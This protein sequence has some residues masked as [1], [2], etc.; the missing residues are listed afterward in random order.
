M[1]W[2]HLTTHD[3]AAGTNY[4]Y[5]ID[6]NLDVPD[7]ASRYQP[8]DVTGFSQVVDPEAFQWQCLDWRGRPWEETI[9]YELH[10]G[11]F[12]PEGTFTAAIAKLDGLVG[13]GRHRHRTDAT[14]RLSGNAELGL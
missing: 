7:P 12:T 13:A 4:R 3:A 11:S 1:G 14:R 5:V 2:F 9:L 6:G 10:V 8:G